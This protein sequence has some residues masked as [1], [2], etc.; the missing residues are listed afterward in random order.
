M[1]KQEILKKSYDFESIIN[2]NICVKN[3]YFSIFYQKNNE[4]NIYGISVP[5]KIGNAVTRNK[6][7]RQ[8]KT[9]IDKNKLSIPKNYDY[10]I[11]IRKGLL[12]IDYIN[13]ETELIN[14]FNNIK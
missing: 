13:K 11:I 14:L 2:K 12:E 9:I 4:K 8:I 6:I 7:K 5:K 3:K 1:K 10:V